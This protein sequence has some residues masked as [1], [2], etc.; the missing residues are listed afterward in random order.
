MKIILT[1]KPSNFCFSEVASTP[2]TVETALEGSEQAKSSVAKY[3][4]SFC[5]IF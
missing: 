5:G 4:F 1:Y 3:I 2:V